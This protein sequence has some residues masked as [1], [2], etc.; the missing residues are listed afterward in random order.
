MLAL[1]GSRAAKFALV[2]PRMVRLGHPVQALFR[3]LTYQQHYFCLFRL[4]I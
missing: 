3:G 1:A 2:G 4:G